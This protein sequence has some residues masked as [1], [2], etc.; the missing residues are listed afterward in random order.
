MNAQLSGIFDLIAADG[1]IIIFLLAAI[2]LI[3]V[4]IYNEVKDRG[5]GDPPG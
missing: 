3:L 2:M 4:H 5:S 1:V